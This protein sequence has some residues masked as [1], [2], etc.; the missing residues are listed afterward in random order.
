MTHQYLMLGVP[1]SVREPVQLK[2]LVSLLETHPDNR[3]E[4]SVMLMQLAMGKLRG[5]ADLD[6]RLLHEVLWVARARTF[7]K[8]AVLA[9]QGHVEMQLMVLLSG[10]ATLFVKVCQLV[11]WFF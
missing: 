2:H 5:L 8:A 1:P 6:P 10:H 7:A 3:T 9:Q 4:Q 11:L